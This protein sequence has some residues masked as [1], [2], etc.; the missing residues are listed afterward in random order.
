MKHARQ[1]WSKLVGQLVAFSLLEA[2]I[3]LLWRDNLLL[4]IILLVAGLAVLSLWHDRYDLTFFLVI[5]VLGS[6]AEAVF[7][8]FGV[9]HY[10]NPTL[11]GV[12]LWFPLAFGTS[13]LIGARLVRTI[14]QLW[15]EARSS[16]SSNG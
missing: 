14:T 1:L 16:R 12:P 7:V 13:G 3:L 5:A 10:A 4:F 6:L 2:A 11:L 15:E 9:W 8:R